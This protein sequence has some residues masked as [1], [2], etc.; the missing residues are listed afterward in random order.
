MTPIRIYFLD[1]EILIDTVPDALVAG[2]LTATLGSDGTVAITRI[3]STYC[4]ASLPW[5]SV[6]DVN[7]NTFATS[8]AVMAYLTAQFTMRRA[9]G[10]IA[11]FTAGQDLSGHF[12]LMFADDG[13]G[14]VVYADPTSIDYTFAGISLGAAVSGTMV[15]V[16]TNGLVV[17]PSW[18]WTP[19]LPVYIGLLGALTQ[20]VPTVGFFHLVGIPPNAT[21]LLVAPGPLVQ[22]A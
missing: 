10:G 5:Q 18:S 8:A 9:V 4:I 2:S 14:S 17:E 3:Q 21:S 22:L 20:T 7:G 15:Q 19:L 11:Y 6:A 16:M 1:N 12:A 13:S